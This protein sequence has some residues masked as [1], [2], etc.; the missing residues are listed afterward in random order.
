MKGLTR[1]NSLTLLFRKAM[2]DLFSIDNAL[3]VYA[4]GTEE[5]TCEASDCSS[6]EYC[7]CTACNCC[8]YCT[9]GCQC[10]E[11][12]KDGNLQVARRLKLGDESYR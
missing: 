7:D 11:A 2:N 1:S 4:S 5:V 9:E 12:I 6:L 8:S 3:I 10:A